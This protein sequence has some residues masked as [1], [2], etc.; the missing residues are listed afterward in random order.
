MSK[1]DF[2]ITAIIALFSVALIVLIVVA[3]KETPKDP[4]ATTA[5]SSAVAH[6]HNGDGV[7]DHDDNYHATEGEKDPNAEDTDI[8]VD[9]E[10]LGGNTDGTTGTEATTGTEG[11]STGSTESTGNAVTGNEIEFDDLLNAGKN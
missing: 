9:V 8:S 1:K 10:N 11:G 6:D 5:P 2:I 3:K 7:P 4:N